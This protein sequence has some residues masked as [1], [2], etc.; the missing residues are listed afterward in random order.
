MTPARSV[1][2]LAGGTILVV[3]FA[4]TS[5]PLAGL[6]FAGLQA[7]GGFR[8]GLA[9]LTA[10]LIGVASLGALVVPQD[11]AVN[12]LV[13]V[14]QLLAAVAFVGGAWSEPGPFFRRATFALTWSAAAAL[15]LSFVAGRGMSWGLLAWETRRQV[16][17]AERS[18][19]EAMKPETMATLYAM[20][21][22]M[23][24][25]LSTA[26]PGLEVL[27]ALAALAAAWQWHVR[28]AREPLGPPLAPFR[29][30]RIADGAVWGVVLATT[31]WIISAKVPGL[32]IA[33]L[34]AGLVL[35]ALYI[36]RGAAVLGA[37]AVTL[38]I[39]AW[40]QATAIVSGLLFAAVTAP[41]L[42]ILGVSDTWLEFRRRLES[43][44]N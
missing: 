3:L 7:V 24:R 20:Y 28:T 10:L 18:I 4:P 40:V 41:G 42:A 23:V 21:E 5:L 31:V 19:V 38:A 12:T 17:F 1:W 43:R 6:A 16:S 14:F 32:R 2:W 35:G 37:A 9:R 25:V 27:G 36:L 29:Q 33:A 8:S 34:N 26:R 44:P 30:F 39:P 13:A 15:A 11:S 22:P